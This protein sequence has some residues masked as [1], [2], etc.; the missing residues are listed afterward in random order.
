M[1]YNVPT[2]SQIHLSKKSTIKT[3]NNYPKKEVMDKFIGCIQEGLVT[4]A[5][6]WCAELLVSGFFVPLWDLLIDYYFKYLVCNYPI[7]IT[8]IHQQQT[9]VNQIKKNYTGNLQALPNN[10]ELRNHL[11]E[12]VTIFCLSEK[13]KEDTIVKGQ[14]KV[15]DENRNKA[16]QII[17][18][19][20]PNLSTDSQ[21]YKHFHS[22]I[23][24][25]YD[26]QTEDTQPEDTETVSPIGLQNC[27]HYLDWFVKDIEHMIAPFHDFKV[28]PTL[29]QRCIWLIWK[30][31]L[32]NLKT[33]PEFTSSLDTLI[34]IFLINYRKKNYNVCTN[35]LWFVLLLARQPEKIQLDHR[36]DFSHH[37]LIRQ[38]AEINFIYQT[39]IQP[40]LTSKA[41]KKV[42]AK[43]LTQQEQS[44]IKFY[45]NPKNKNFLKTINDVNL[46]VATQKTQSL[47]ETEANPKVAIKKSSN[48]SSRPP[49]SSRID[50]KSSRIDP[51]N[52]DELI[53][54]VIISG[55]K[56]T[57]KSKIS[58][59]E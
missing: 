5:N 50:P 3:V 52:S 8:Y 46:L 20:N 13:Q 39:L 31:L 21:I 6:Y 49:K 4:D 14:I 37:Q 25:Y 29:A 35:L 7:L 9:L 44:K 54:P 2:E 30:F 12:I 55:R 40:R 45:E 24:N 42:R 34:E 19:L 18:L 41:D 56:K 27:R 16:D 22:F 26:V 28:P 51:N 57:C 47:N 38:S 32:S 10:Q 48:G 59:G 36:V 17:Q 11:S 43:K 58:L 33:Q 23:I 1:N 15:S 53:I